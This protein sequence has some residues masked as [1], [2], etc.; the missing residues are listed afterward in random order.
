M[1]MNDRPWSPAGRLG[2]RGRWTRSVLELRRLVRC[3]FAGPGSR[4]AGVR[5]VFD[6][7]GPAGQQVLDVVNIYISIVRVV[8]WATW[9]GRRVIGIAIDRHQHGVVLNCLNAPMWGRRAVLCKVR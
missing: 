6:S 1:N 4:A 8:A 5:G 2:A 3:F 7:S 9:D